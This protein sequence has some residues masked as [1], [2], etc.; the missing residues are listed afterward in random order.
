MTFDCKPAYFGGKKF[1][2]F[3]LRTVRFASELLECILVSE[4]EHLENMFQQ[5]AKKK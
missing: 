2:I 5:L 3:E 1:G 4:L